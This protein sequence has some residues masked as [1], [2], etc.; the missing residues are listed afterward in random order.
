MPL[1]YI[2]ITIFYGST[3]KRRGVTDRVAEESVIFISEKQNKE[4]KERTAAGEQS[5]WSRT[6]VN[7]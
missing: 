1:F 3:L 7:S 6:N 5:K 2:I 4:S